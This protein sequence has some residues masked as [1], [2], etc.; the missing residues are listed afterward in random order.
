MNIFQGNYELRL[1]SWYQLR[2]EIS[3]LDRQNQCIRIDDWWQK[4][5][6]VNHY[7][8]P[9]FMFEWPGPWELI[10]ENNYCVYARALGMVYTLLLLG[11][12]DIDIVDAKDDNNEDVVLVLVD[13]AK[14]ILNY[15][16]DTVVNNCLQDFKITKRHDLAHI[17][18]KIGNI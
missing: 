9:D 4:C 18:K 3:E 1:K 14:Y 16:P 12:N 15:W 8:H 5:P 10:S 17:I 13:D 11:I 6:L 7:L 2:Q